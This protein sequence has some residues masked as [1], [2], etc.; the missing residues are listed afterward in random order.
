MDWLELVMAAALGL[1]VPLLL[2]VWVVL[3]AAIGQWLY[4]GARNLGRP[5]SLIE[6]RIIGQCQVHIR[7]QRHRISRIEQ[8]TVY[9][10]SYEYAG[11]LYEIEQLVRDEAQVMLDESA[12]TFR[13]YVP[14]D[15]PDDAQPEYNP[16]QLI[17]GLILVGGMAYGSWMMAPF[18][19]FWK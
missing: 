19:I 18:L 6:A 16:D 4:D 2:L 7:I 13:L 12:G 11:T 5:H 17:Y 9:R 10:L 8:R 14:H 1:F 15:R 3:M